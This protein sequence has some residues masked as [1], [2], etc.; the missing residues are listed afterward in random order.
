MR[1]LRRDSEISDRRQVKASHRALWR[2]RR[3]VLPLPRAVGALET[4]DPG[5]ATRGTRL[6]ARKK[7]Q[8][9][10]FRVSKMEKEQPQARS[11]ADSS[12]RRP[13]LPRSVRHAKDK[14]STNT[15]R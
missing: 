12:A 2:M 14:S 5:I 15:S 8:G 4:A 11:Y 1:S 3:K 6:A 9:Q 10:C 13:E 7:C